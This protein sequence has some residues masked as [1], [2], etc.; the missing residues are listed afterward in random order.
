MEALKKQSRLVLPLGQPFKYILKFAICSIPL[1]FLEQTLC[2]FIKA[3]KG[4][5]D[6]C[7]LHL[8]DRSD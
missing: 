5:K 6:S 3:L 2:V 4:K 1:F 8:P 7:Q